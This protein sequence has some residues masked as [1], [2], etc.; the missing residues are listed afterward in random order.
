MTDEQLLLITA[1]VDGELSPAETTSFRHLLDL[2]PPARALYIRLKDDSVRLRNL[3][4]ETPP[5]NLQKKVMSKIAALTPPPNKL[6]VAIP[7]LPV[8][9]PAAGSHPVQPA[10]TP[11]GRENTS[12]LERKSRRWIPVAIAASLLLAVSGSSF[13]YFSRGSANAG[14]MARNPKRPPPATQNGAKDPEWAKWLPFENGPRPVAPT[15][16]PSHLH[17]TIIAENDSFVPERQPVDPTATATAPLPRLAP[18]NSLMGATVVP[19]IPLPD[20]LSV[21]V[22]FLKPLAEFDRDDIRKQL[23]DELGR[24]P[25]FRIDLFTRHLSRGVESFRNAA[26]AAG[27]T[28]Y[29]DPSSLERVNKSQVSSVVVYIESLTPVEI[30]E[31]FVKLNAEDAKISPRVFDI[32]HAVPVVRADQDSLRSILGIEPGLFKRPAQEKSGSDPNKPINAGTVDQ[33]VKSISAG[34]PIEKNAM[35][36]TWL[37]TVARTAPNTS[38]ELQKF[39][40]KRGDRKSNAVPVVIVIRPGNG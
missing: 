31:L 13:W 35:L 2:S 25:A 37:P 18:N 21:R 7:R 23:S 38:G 6:P 28:V 5:A 39:L 36:M 1:A 17:E 12:R 4:R 34:K 26:K 16:I 22:P 30:A 9:L 24:D 19:D 11:V 40:S 27:I 15:P 33:I 20:L 3:A 14:T 8:H 10:T 29:V 32:V